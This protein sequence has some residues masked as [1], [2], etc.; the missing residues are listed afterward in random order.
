MG[1]GAMSYRPTEINI[2]SDWSPSDIVADID[3]MAV[4]DDASYFNG[5][6]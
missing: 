3:R 4:I 5:V 2:Y 6:M 1:F